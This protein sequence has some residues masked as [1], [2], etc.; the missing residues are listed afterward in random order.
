[1]PLAHTPKN[2]TRKGRKDIIHLT[3]PAERTLRNKR[4]D[5]KSQENSPTTPQPSTSAQADQRDLTESSVKRRKKTKGKRLSSKKLD[6]ALEILED[7]LERTAEADALALETEDSTEEITQRIT[8]VSL[9]TRQPVV[10]LQRINMALNLKQITELMPGYDGNPNQ[11]DQ[12]V[13]TV[14]T[15]YDNSAAADRPLFLVIVKSKLKDR[16]FQVINEG[17]HA[18]W[19]EIKEALITE[20]KPKIDLQTAN[21]NLFGT[22]QRANELTKDYAERIKTMKRQL[23]DVTNREIQAALRPQ[24]LTLNAQLAKQAFEANLLNTALKTIVISA[25]K[26][27]LRESIDFA[28]TQEQKFFNQQNQP[29]DTNQVPKTE[30]RKRG[31]PIPLPQPRSYQ[32]T[33]SRPQ[34]CY[35]C[36]K[37]GH[38]SPE[39]PNKQ[40]KIKKEIVKQEYN[41]PP[42]RPYSGRYQ[43]VNYNKIPQPNWNQTRQTNYHTN[44]QNPNIHSNRQIENP[45]YFQTRNI[46]AEPPEETEVQQLNSDAVIVTKESEN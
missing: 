10:V 30:I 43:K 24:T 17:T 45:K 6:E 36:G 7:Q 26:A 46:H 28:L 21:Q 11:L 19:T 37:P 22:K 27:T 20:I 44:I 31:D 18:T 29:T 41:K 32:Q 3:Q 4:I 23:D 1:M 33:Q 38:Y 42:S 12:Y 13:Q 34:Y 14:Q 2:S 40:V 35:D 25:N 39:C 16:A 9:E 5:F 8:E 15:L